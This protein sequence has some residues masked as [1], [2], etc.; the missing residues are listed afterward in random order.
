MQFIRAKKN[1]SEG[2]NKT[3]PNIKWG[4]ILC[5]FT[6]ALV[7][8]SIIAY[9][10]M[11]INDFY[12]KVRSS[13]SEIRFAYEK[14]EIVGAMHVEYDKRKEALDKDF[15]KKEK[16]SE[17]KLIDEVVGQMKTDESPTPVQ[18]LSK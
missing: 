7:L 12:S 17:E 11:Q 15:M 1:Q 5:G 13:W 4:R 3:T 18:K 16:S 14:P 10:V 6:L 8:L 2:P 9:A